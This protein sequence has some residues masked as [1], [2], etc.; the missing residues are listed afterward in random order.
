MIH[1][2]LPARP[3]SSGSA[4]LVEDDPL[5]LDAMVELVTELGFRPLIF[6]NADEALEFMREGASEIRLLWTDFH[7]PGTA[8]GGKL[9]VEA[10]SVIPGLPIVVTSGVRGAAYRLESGITYVS[11]P[12]S[13]EIMEALILRLTAS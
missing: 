6:S 3:A 1:N 5:Q 9:A 4:M 11:K 7:M 12:W 13:V 8:N 2:D 10:M